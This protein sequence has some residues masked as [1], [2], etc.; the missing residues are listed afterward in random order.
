MSDAQRPPVDELLDDEVLAVGGLADVVDG[1][2]VGV[3]EGGGRPRLA[4]EPL[5]DVALIAV[6]R[7]A[8]A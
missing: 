4:Q 1:D 5:D 6:A 3:V 8:A 2:D 7:A